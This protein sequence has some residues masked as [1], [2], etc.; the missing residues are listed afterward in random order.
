MRLTL[1]SQLPIHRSQQYLIQNA[2]IAV[3]SKLL[4]PERFHR[5]Q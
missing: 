2:G 3:E 1:E 5:Q 4:I